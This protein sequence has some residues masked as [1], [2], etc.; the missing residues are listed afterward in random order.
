MEK[1][2]S[3]SQELL[4]QGVSDEEILEFLKVHGCS[5]LETMYVFR[6]T[7]NIDV[8][9]TISRIR[10]SRAWADHKE[11]IESFRQQLTFE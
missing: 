9:E 2:V 3:I 6:V 10:D 8:D 7:K 4:G 5:L 11:S 1:L